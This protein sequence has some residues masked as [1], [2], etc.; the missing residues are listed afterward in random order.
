MRTNLKNR[1]KTLISG[2][3]E[4]NTMKIYYVNPITGEKTLYGQYP[5]DKDLNVTVDSPETAATMIKLRS[6]E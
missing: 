4:Q 1:V 6:H 2:K 5:N 3:T